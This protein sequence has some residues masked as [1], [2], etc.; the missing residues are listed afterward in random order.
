[1]Y[2]I[3]GNESSNSDSESS[4]NCKENDLLKSDFEDT[5]RNLLMY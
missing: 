5:Q 4:L 1:M 2:G 3:S